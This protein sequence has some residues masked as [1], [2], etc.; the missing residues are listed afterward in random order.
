MPVADGD[1]RDC[2]DQLGGFGVL[3]HAAARPGPG[4]LH[5]VLVLTEGGEHED[6]TPAVRRLLVMCPVASTP[7]IL[8]IWTKTGAPLAQTS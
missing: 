5:H 1:D 6:P 7:S 4:R 3:E 2:A 8:G